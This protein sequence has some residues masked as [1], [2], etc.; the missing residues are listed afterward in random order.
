MEHN[1]V[2]EMRKKADFSLPFLLAQLGTLRNNSVAE[3]LIS[4]S[5]HPPQVKGAVQW[6]PPSLPRG[7]ELLLLPHFSD[8]YPWI[9]DLQF[10]IN[11]RKE[12]LH[13]FTC[14]SSTQLWINIFTFCWNIQD[15]WIQDFVQHCF[16]W[17]T[18]GTQGANVLPVALLLMTE[19][20][21]EILSAFYSFKTVKPCAVS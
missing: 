5:N 16:P 21:R 12:A 15:R 17:R 19:L 9:N 4:F 1:P 20:P 13:H 18:R 3:L 10:Y 7:W 6:S 11:L 2:K 14:W 8:F